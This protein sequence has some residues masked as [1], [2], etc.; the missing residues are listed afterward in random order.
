MEEDVAVN[1]MTK[2]SAITSVLLCLAYATRNRRQSLPSKVDYGDRVGPRTVWSRRY[3]GIECGGG[4]RDGGQRLLRT[5]TNLLQCQQAVP[6]R[7]SSL[8]IDHRA[9]CRGLR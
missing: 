3:W 8:V 1:G 7:T 5:T 9:T 2:L 4:E 6:Y